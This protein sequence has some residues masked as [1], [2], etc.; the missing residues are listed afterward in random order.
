MSGID[1]ACTYR[2]SVLG[3]ALAHIQRVQ[4]LLRVA[5]VGPEYF[6]SLDEPLLVL[7]AQQHGRGVPDVAA[8]VRALGHP[9]G[10]PVEDQAKKAQR[11]YNGEPGEEA[12][13]SRHLES[14]QLH[15]FVGAMVDMFYT[16]VLLVLFVLFHLASAEQRTLQVQNELS[17]MR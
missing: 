4:V 13:E 11:E 16:L 9:L 17:E 3:R 6:D 1:C 14:V 5:S 7:V 8:A 12:L 15:L 10:L 2:L